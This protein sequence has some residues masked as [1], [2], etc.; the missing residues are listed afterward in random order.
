M[1]IPAITPPTVMPHIG[2]NAR[3]LTCFALLRYL[4]LR[5]A[6]RDGSCLRF[7]RTASRATGP[8]LTAV[9]KHPRIPGSGTDGHRP[10]AQPP[11]C[12]P[13]P[14]APDPTASPGAPPGPGTN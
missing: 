4:S 14:A 6:L 7:A 12:T 3:I 5:G 1:M 2:G 8:T 13:P 10:P 11:G 9:R